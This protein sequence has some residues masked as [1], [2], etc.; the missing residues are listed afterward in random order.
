MRAFI[1]HGLPFPT[2]WLDLPVKVMAWA[3]PPQLQQLEENASPVKPPA[4]STSHQHTARPV[5]STP[6]ERRLRLAVEEACRRL[7]DS[8]AT[9]T[10][11]DRRAGDGDC[12]ETLRRGAHGV[13]EAIAAQHIGFARPS[14]L[15]ADLG[16]IVAQHMGGSSGALYS[17]GLMRA[18]AHL[19]A[20]QDDVEMPVPA[21]G[22]ALQSGGGCTGG[23]AMVGLDS[24]FFLFRCSLRLGTA[25]DAM[26]HYGGAAEGDRTMLDA[27]LP[28]ARVLRQGEPFGGFF[29]SFCLICCAE[30]CH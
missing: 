23:G 29:F 25:L 1:D 8:E 9:I 6:R 26:M 19:Q 7:I 12:G 28:V 17:L 3:P 27:L 20:A 22:D 18:S 14:A 5:P 4:G 11:L 30:R 16:H 24:F 13:L 21:W 15:L 10:E 2:Q